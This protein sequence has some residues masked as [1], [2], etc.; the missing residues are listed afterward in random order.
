VW[1][2]L[3]KR[4]PRSRAAH[5]K[6]AANPTAKIRLFM[7]KSSSNCLLKLSRISLNQL[8]CGYRF[9]L[10]SA[11][12]SFTGRTR[13]VVIVVQYLPFSLRSPLSSL[14]CAQ[15]SEDA[16][17]A[18]ARASAWTHEGHFFLFLRMLIGRG[19]PQQDRA[20]SPNTLFGRLTE[21]LRWLPS[22]CSVT[23]AA[24]PNTRISSSKRIRRRTNSKG[25]RD[26]P[27]HLCENLRYLRFQLLFT[28]PISPT[29]SAVGAALR[30][31]VGSRGR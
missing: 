14:Q 8:L 11:V 30:P 10:E 23:A 3:S 15:W 9:S 26:R 7:I 31:V 1:A 4:P 16:N 20:S 19:P 13:V 5:P 22:A 27:Y 6:T 17:L 2:A 29:L 24:P 21:I 12:A 18:K 28:L 25:S